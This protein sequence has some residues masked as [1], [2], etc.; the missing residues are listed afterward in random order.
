MEGP[1][2]EG[3]R[4]KAFNVQIEDE[5][6][7]EINVGMSEE[8]LSLLVTLNRKDLYVMSSVVE[9][10]GVMVVE[11]RQAECAGGMMECLDIEGVKEGARIECNGTNMENK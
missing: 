5:L 8:I 1:A 11:V 10:R 2:P 6:R 7:E 9:V 3:G 4:N